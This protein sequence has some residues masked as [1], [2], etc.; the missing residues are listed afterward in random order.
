VSP[1][2]RRILFVPPTLIGITLAT[3]LLIH[4]AP[5]DPAAIRSGQGR[6]VTPEA[7][8][9]FRD[10]YELDRP[11]GPRYLA[12]VAR[13]ARLDFGTSLVD[14]RPVRE[15]LAEALPITLALALAA[16]FLAYFVAI[17]LGCALGAGDGRRWARLTNG[18]LYVVYALPVAAVSLL[19][20]SLGAPYGGR[21]PGAV[22]VAAAC[23]ALAT[24]VRL[25]RHQRAALLD[26]L[27][28][29]YVLTARAKGA[30]PTQVVLGHAL[31][32]ALLPMVT[33][34]GSELPVLLSGSVIVEQVF[35]IRGLGLMG[36]DAVLAR[37]YPMLL[38][39][40]TLGAVITLAGVLAAD[41]VYGLVDPRLR[42]ERA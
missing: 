5:G 32:N 41:A 29:D 12:W 24:S 20:L 28:A 3:F 23:L 22:L 19:A 4:L 42:S 15:K 27:S 40:T 37:D 38:G 21:G 6:G 11:L 8:A 35:G 14:G 2:W 13:S 18:G 39:L 7:L 16:T 1:L 9:A 10:A 17:P 25:S 26:A 31:R 30:S 34:L 36:F 33:L